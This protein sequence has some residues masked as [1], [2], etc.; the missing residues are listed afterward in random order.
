MDDFSITAKVDVPGTVE[1]LWP[2]MEAGVRDGIVTVDDAADLIV[3]AI[4]ESIEVE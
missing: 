1:R 3:E 2:L 4:I